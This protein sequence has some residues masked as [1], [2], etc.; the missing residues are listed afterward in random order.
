MPRKPVKK[1]RVRRKSRNVRCPS[2]CVKKSRKVVKK[3][4]KASR[5]KSRKASRKAR[6]KKK[7][8]RKRKKSRKKKV[9][10]KR[11]KSRKKFRMKREMV[12]P[13]SQ[14]SAVKTQKRQETDQGKQRPVHGSGGNTKAWQAANIS[15]I[16]R[17]RL[18]LPQKYGSIERPI[19]VSPSSRKF[20]EEL[21]RHNL[22][23]VGSAGS[24][25]SVG[26]VGAG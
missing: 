17:R 25:G 3:S 22:G 2:G 11:K 18:S 26:S 13:K 7:V 10:R 12:N 6:K 4:R 19:V 9:S 16:S 21:R 14:L 23:S 5:K 1:S 20:A 24:V 8:S 15:Q